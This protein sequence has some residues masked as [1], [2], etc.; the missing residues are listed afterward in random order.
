MLFYRKYHHL[1]CPNI[2]KNFNAKKVAEG[3]KYNSG[4]NTEWVDAEALRKLIKAHV[5]PNFTV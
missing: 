1:T 3:F 4:Q 2:F 5:D